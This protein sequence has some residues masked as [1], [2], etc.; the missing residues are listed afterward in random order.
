MKG[1]SPLHSA[2]K[3][4]KAEAIGALLN[5]GADL[6][7]RNEDG[8]TPLHQAARKG[9]KDVVGALL[10]SGADP[11]ALDKLGRTPFDVIPDGAP[12]VGTSAY[13]RLHDARWD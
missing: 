6:D 10:N 4:G 9:Q 7:A 1:D 11:R 13:W 2:A 12:L 8:S 3:N 5:A